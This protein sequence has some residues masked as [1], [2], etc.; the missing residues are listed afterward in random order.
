[1]TLLCPACGSENLVVLDSRAH[2]RHNW[3]RRRSC[4]SCGARFTTYELLEDKVLQYE[5]I[6]MKLATLRKMIADLNGMA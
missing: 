6:E 3:R 4:G 2:G 5:L 1:M